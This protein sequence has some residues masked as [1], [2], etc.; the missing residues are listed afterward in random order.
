MLKIFGHPISIKVN[1]VRYLANYLGLEHEFTQI[2]PMAGDLQSED[3]L[4]VNPL[5]KMPA[6]T[7]DGFNLGESNAILRYL[8][9]KANSDLYPNDAKQRAIVDQW[10]DFSSMH[11]GNAFV[12]IFFI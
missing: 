3:Y 12:K 1:K 11:L 8:T 7:D 4:K 5:G 10:L 2:N 6:I 9:T